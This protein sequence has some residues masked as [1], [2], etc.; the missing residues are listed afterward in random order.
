MLGLGQDV[1]PIVISSDPLASINAAYNANPVAAQQVAITT[2]SSA[3]QMITCSDG[4]MVPQGGSCL[5][6]TVAVTSPSSGTNYGT[7]PGPGCPG[8]V[9]PC[10]DGS[11]PLTLGTNADGTP[12]FSICQQTLM[13][14]ALA[15]LAFLILL[16][17]M[18]R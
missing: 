11:T 14:G 9:A 16:G 8:Y 17:S 4:S 12:M 3:V 1:A 13:Y 2:P 15:G 6:G 10:S 5:T 7:C 18:K